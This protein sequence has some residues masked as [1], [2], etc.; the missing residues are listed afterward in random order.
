MELRVASSVSEAPAWRR[1]PYRVFFPLGAALSWAGVLHWL[2]LALGITGEYRSIFHSMAQIQGFL[3]SFAVGFL[4]TMI[5]RRTGTA[6]PAPWQMVVALAA[7][8]GTTVSAWFEQWALA[9]VFWLALL[10][11]VIGFAL[12]RF[13]EGDVPPSF[14]WVIAALLLGV[15][16]A[17]LAGFGAATERIWLHD[18]GRGLVL[19]GVM[20]GL[21]LGV[22]GFLIPAICRAAPPGRLPRAAHLALVLVFVA[23]FLLEQESIRAAFALRAVAVGL[24]LIPSARLWLRPTLPGLHRRLVFIAAWMMPLGY[25][26]VAVLPQYRRI[27]LHLVFIGCYALLTLS[28]SVHVVLSHGGRAELLDMAPHPLRA[29]GALLALAL[30][31]RLLVDLDPARF[32]LWLGLAAASF[33]AATL[34]WGWL[35]LRRP[36]PALVP[37]TI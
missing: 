9:Q 2:L 20:S 28:V 10:A 7:P 32:N 19:Q 30:A 22:G 4:F 34:C 21:I 37:A 6:P 24:A 12:R 1:E 36:R 29:L 14:V 35:L 3:A 18:V 27:G 17:I 11:V 8:I 23:S 16:G 15:A 26:V 31:C 33:L 13:R 5:P 25:A